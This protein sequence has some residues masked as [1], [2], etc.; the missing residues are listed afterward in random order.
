[1][2]KE[3]VFFGLGL[4][5]KKKKRQGKDTRQ[6][7]IVFHHPHL[8]IL[9]K[10]IN[11]V[12]GKQHQKCDQNFSESLP[13]FYGNGLVILDNIALDVFQVFQELPDHQHKEQVGREGKDQRRKVL[14]VDKDSEERKY[15]K[16]S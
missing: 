4:P 9:P 8:G 5:N 7:E 11:G 13:V 10:K 1:V 15:G 16:N 2:Q 3:V 14:V 6:V 12:Q